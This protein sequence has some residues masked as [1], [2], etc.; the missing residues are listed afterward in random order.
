MFT[1][2]DADIMVFISGDI[3][4]PGAETIPNSL[5]LMFGES[6]EWRSVKC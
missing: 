6:R 5:E 1:E 4:N 3:E 2:N